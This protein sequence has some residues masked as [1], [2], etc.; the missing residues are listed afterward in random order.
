V[1]EQRYGRRTNGLTNP[2]ASINH[3]KIIKTLAKAISEIADALPRVSLQS[4]LY[5]TK[6]MEDAVT[7][8]YVSIFQFFARA[9]QWYQGN[10][11]QRLIH[12]ITHPVELHYDDL[13]NDIKESS[14]NIDR[15]S[16]LGAQAETRDMH[17]TVQ[18]M[19][20][21]SRN[22][23]RTVDVIQAENRDMY[24]KFY[25]LMSVVEKIHTTTSRKRLP[26]PVKEPFKLT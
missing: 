7:R 1:E 5:P 2:K 3:E 12:S 20:A 18:T 11:V 15:L 13:L 17:R 22:T 8:L 19:Q 9:R 10:S 14:R 26:D 6:Q 21:E 16:Y 23:Q 24:Q 25:T 4:S